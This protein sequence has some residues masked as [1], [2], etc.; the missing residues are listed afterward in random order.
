MFGGSVRNYAPT[1]FMCTHKRHNNGIF[2]IFQYCV[3][4]Q[5]NK[6]PQKKKH[7]PKHTIYRICLC[8]RHYG[9]VIKNM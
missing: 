9:Q 2:N 1:S 5:T 3:D 6:Q 8:T 7:V 4:K